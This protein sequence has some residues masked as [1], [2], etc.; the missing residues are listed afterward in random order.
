MNGLILISGDHTYRDHLGVE[1]PSEHNYIHR[2]NHPKHRKP[3]QVLANCFEFRESIL[4]ICHPNPVNIPN[5]CDSE[6]YCMT[7]IL[8]TLD[9]VPYRASYGSLFVSMVSMGVEPGRKNPRS[10]R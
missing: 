7:G 1:S 4:S 5:M 10:H 2:T 9:T 6:T 8:E 3:P